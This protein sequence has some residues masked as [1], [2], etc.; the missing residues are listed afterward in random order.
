VGR[1]VMGLKWI[2]IRQD[3]VNK[4]WMPGWDKVDNATW[5]AT[6]IRPLRFSWILATD[7]FLVSMIGGTR[8]LHEK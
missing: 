6:E 1:N 7:N 2:N 4:V 5:V 3:I 8:N